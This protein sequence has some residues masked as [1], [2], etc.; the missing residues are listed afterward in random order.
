VTERTLIQAAAEELG[1][2]IG[3]LLD[4]SATVAAASDTVT[5]RWVLE[6]TFVG[7]IAGTLTVGVGQASA[8]TLAG[9]IMAL[10]EAPPPEAVADTL[11]EV[12]GQALGALSQRPGFEG[13][14]MVEAKVVPAAPA[15]TPSFMRLTAGAQFAATIAFWS[16]L[17]AGRAEA[18]AAASAHAMP[19]PPNLDLILDIDLPLTVRFGETEMTL[20]ALARIVPG[21]VIDL[22]RSPDDPVDILVN[23]RL[24]ARAEVVVVSGNYGVR[25]VE[26]ISAA[27]R[28]KTV[29][30]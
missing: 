21:S 19:T 22:G 29:A 13:L 23:G 14:R 27:D 2:I 3:A 25:I 26:V 17:D 28:L 4:A 12:C 6:L 5:P 15:K 8:E 24:I 20:S 18:P 16:S 11:Q 30:A 10:D 1:T 9:L 7:P